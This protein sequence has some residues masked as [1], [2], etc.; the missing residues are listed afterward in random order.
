MLNSQLLFIWKQMIKQ[1]TSINFWNSI[2]KNER[3]DFKST[4]FD[5]FS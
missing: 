5:G 2:F 3:I 1:N 4:D